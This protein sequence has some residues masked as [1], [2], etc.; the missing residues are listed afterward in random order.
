MHPGYLALP[1]YYLPSLGFQQLFAMI[2]CMLH[3]Q[4][5][6]AAA[7]QMMANVALVGQSAQMPLYLSSRI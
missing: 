7:G 4:A 5:N 3:L 6:A 2:V 1:F